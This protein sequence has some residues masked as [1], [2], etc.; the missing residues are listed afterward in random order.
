M[1]TTDLNQSF[2]PWKWTPYVQNQLLPGLHGSMLLWIY[3]FLIR[4]ILSAADFRTFLCENNVKKLARLYVL[5][6]FSKLHILFLMGRDEETCISTFFF[7][8][9]Q[10]SQLYF[11]RLRWAN[12]RV[13]TIALANLC[14]MHQSKR[15][16]THNQAL[17]HESETL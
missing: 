13:E 2:M 14:F 5:L 17:C 16:T 15:P 1:P 8:L 11:L 4:V 12:G 9:T 7:S 10:L 6:W 3:T